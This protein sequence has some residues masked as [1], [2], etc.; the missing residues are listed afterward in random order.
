MSTLT[1][2]VLDFIWSD[3]DRMEGPFLGD[4]ADRLETEVVIDEE[5]PRETVEFPGKGPGFRDDVMMMVLI[6][7]AKANIISIDKV[8]NF[9]A[10]VKTILGSD[11]SNDTIHDKLTSGIL[12]ENANHDSDIFRLALG[13]ILARAAYDRVLTYRVETMLVSSTV[14]A[15]N[16][17]KILKSVADGCVFTKLRT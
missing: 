5:L 14:C 12:A 6:L 16:L 7:R 9:D 3:L 1:P 15:K 8:E 2:V 11:I 10:W 4:L 17:F 13:R